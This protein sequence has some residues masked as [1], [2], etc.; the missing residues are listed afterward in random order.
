MTKFSIKDL[1]IFI[2]ALFLLEKLVAE[3]III[4]KPEPKIQEIN[5]KR[6][7]TTKNST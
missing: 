6:N 2:I 4:P 5:K 1:I 3:E 7:N